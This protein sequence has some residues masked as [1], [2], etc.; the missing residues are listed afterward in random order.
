MAYSSQA[1]GDLPSPNTAPAQ[2]TD[3]LAVSAPALL[4]SPGNDELFWEKPS[5]HPIFEG[6]ECVKVGESRAPS[7]MMNA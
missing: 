7:A 4:G 2:G 6:S 3:T 1:S 5:L